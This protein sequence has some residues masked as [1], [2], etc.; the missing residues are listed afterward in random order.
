M[1]LAVDVT[2]LAPNKRF[3]VNG[4]FEDHGVQPWEALFDGGTEDDILVPPASYRPAVLINTSGTTGQP[5]FV[6]HTPATLAETVNLMIEG[7]G[8]SDDDVMILAMPMA[9]MSGLA[10]F[11]VYIQS[12]VPFVL[13]E[14]FDA[15]VVLDTIE[16][17]RRHFVRGIPLPVCGTARA[18]A[19][20]AAESDVFA[21]VH[22]RRGRLPD[23]SA[24]AGHCDLRRPALQH[25]GRDGSP[26][27]P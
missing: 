13:M 4:N 25:V 22:Y 20:P 3:V 21:D 11:L 15:D 18:P 10:C 24:E 7:W 17:Y 5:K 23:R 6:A 19:N 27:N 12:G 14:S 9:H 1:S 2:I 16:R 8:L 26:W